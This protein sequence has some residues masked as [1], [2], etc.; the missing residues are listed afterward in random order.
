MRK[1][2]PLLSLICFLLLAMIVACSMTGRDQASNCICT[3]DAFALESAKSKNVL[4][5]SRD[6]QKYKTVKIGKQTWMAEN[7]N[8]KMPNSYCYGENAENCVKYG[9]LYTWDAAKEAC[10]AGWHLPSQAELI[11]LF[12]TSGGQMSA[13]RKLKSSGGWNNC[14][15]KVGNGLDSYGFAALPAG[16]RYRDDDYNIEGYYG[17]FWSS[18]E[19]TLDS[20]YSMYMYCNAD[21]VDLFGDNKNRALSVRCIKDEVPDTISFPRISSSEN[22]SEPQQNGF[23][24]DSRDGQTYKI[25]RIGSQKW[26]AQNLN[27]ETP[28]SYCYND[29]TENCAK[30]G[31][32]YTW[33]AAMDSVGI[34]ASTGKECGKDKDCHFM[35]YPVRGICPDGFHLPT[36]TE[37]NT[38]ISAGYQIF[39]DSSGF[40]ASYGGFR[41]FD[42]GYIFSN[43]NAYYWTS[44]E[45]D[46]GKA[47]YTKLRRWNWETSIDTYE[48]NY[49]YSVRCVQDE[50]M[51]S[52]SLIKSAGKFDGEPSLIVIPASNTVKGL[53]TDSRDGK[54]YKTVTIGSQTW[55]AENLNY[56]ME[57]SHC[58]DDKARKCEKYGRLYEWAAA[59]NACPAGW[60]LPT[61]KEW[62]ILVSSIGGPSLAGLKFR[63]SSGWC[64]HGITETTYG[65]ST[66][67]FRCE[68][69]CCHTNGTDLYGF[70]VLPASSWDDSRWNT[71]GYT[72]FFW[73]AT[74]HGTD[75]AVSVILSGDDNDIEFS[76]Y[77]KSKGF[78]VR[79]ILDSIVS[80]SAF[81]VQKPVIPDS[82]QSP[83]TAV[84]PDDSRSST[85]MAGNLLTDTRDGLTYK[86]VT[87]GDQTWM[88]ENLNYNSSESHCYNDSLENCAKYGRLYTWASA[89]KACPV[90][91]HLP[92]LTE[93]DT[94]VYSVGGALTAGKVLKST[95]GWYGHGN[96][97]DGYGFS[98]LPVGIR[99]S[100]G[101]FDIFGR[102]TYF[103]SSTEHG[104]NEAY[105]LNLYYYGDYDDD[106]VREKGVTGF[107]SYYSSERVKL[108][109]DYKIN[110]APV[111]CIKNAKS[112]SS[113]L[114][115]TSS[116][117]KSPAQNR[118]NVFTDSRDNR[119]YRTVSI[120]NQ[121]WMAEN[122]K[123]KTPNSYCYEDKPFN[124]A[125]Y[126]RL[127]TWTEA[128]GGEDSFP[129]YP[130]Q[131]VCPAG[132]HLPTQTEWRALVASVGGIVLAGRKLKAVS[133][134]ANYW[135]DAK[136]GTDDYDFSA[137][138][139]GKKDENGKYVGES[140]DAYFW[141]A[142]GFNGK[143]SYYLNLYFGQ[144]N[145][146]QGFVKRNE[147]MSVRCVKDEASEISGIGDSSSFASS[148]KSL[149]LSSLPK[150][151][152]TDSRDGKI[153]GIVTIGYQ[154]WMSENLNF[155]AANSYCYKDNP[156]N[157]ATYGRLY[158]WSAAMDSIGDFSQH[159]KGCG[160]GKSC[161]P[162]YP[163]RG[164][165][166]EGFH[167]PTTEEFK[168]LYAFAGGEHS[169]GKRLKS[170]SDW[171]GWSTCR[172]AGRFSCKT[173]E[174][175]NGTDDYGFTMLPAGRWFG[176]FEYLHDEAFFWTS[177]A[178]SSGNGSTEYIL[179]NAYATYLEYDSFMNMDNEGP[180]VKAFQKS[181]G[182]SVRC[183]KD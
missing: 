133:G 155:Q 76:D 38:L 171:S 173:S 70:S 2:I 84:V 64:N 78:S 40:E 162:S 166:P 19:N 102:H 32:L 57:N 95:E 114:T 100:Y 72:T 77:E 115:R 43:K 60:R 34:Y 80:P 47:Y 128:M 125:K 51:E 6:C 169:A 108:V 117:E 17:F 170:R 88:A 143:D 79:C 141:G 59:R 182:F 157:C 159:G 62:N 23:I 63:T 56:K 66:I 73:S 4:F 106:Y 27:Y 181:N 20:A 35:I 151:T 164:I 8:Y 153:Y 180:Y 172:W 165:C 86:T 71:E 55:M 15:N 130:I 33:S 44:A 150:E 16:I 113:R 149:F 93:W 85:G 163:V 177:E 97:V 28:N 101:A 146:N 104:D 65:E 7:L 105:G 161:N 122:L 154:T 1:R 124:C 25:E 10:P 89:E 54:K 110:A 48:K 52:D 132:F 147:A 96:G 49:A 29:S 109:Y 90:G 99:F 134:W 9:R 98:A 13:G 179:G 178:Y 111:R 75:N 140:Y 50:S 145:I 136:L 103:W 69:C 168:T 135:P 26:M 91:W 46:A 3:A 41:H 92:S 42:G 138:P 18:T 183:V 67:D 175:G 121:V 11:T 137:L 131:G 30:Y 87:I 37:W 160:D 68:N 116:Q 129:I 14:E 158:T 107:V 36:Q 12:Y 148:D 58:L 81:S 61:K 21:N 123:F 156:D 167:L 152:F 119:T 127:Y 126:G 31:R 144:E 53:F 45:H 5:D 94:L 176:S 83:Q 118:K 139:A 74:E 24:T 112:K 82:V 39:V 120:G 174:S 22:P 142:T